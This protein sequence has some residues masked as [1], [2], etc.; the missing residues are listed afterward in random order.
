MKTNGEQKGQ[1]MGGF[2]ISENQ[3][4]WVKAGVVN[5][6]T[7]ENAFDC[8]SCTFDKEMSRKLS[9]ATTAPVSWREVMRHQPNKEC[10][11]MLTGRVLFKLCSHNYECKDCAYDQLL[12]EYEQVL[13]AE[14]RSVHSVEQVNPVA[15]FMAPMLCNDCAI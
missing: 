15:D 4:I 6:R 13:C 9:Q 2:Y 8:T 5:F 11:H 7:C 12:Y 1:S 10:R 14:D 3:C